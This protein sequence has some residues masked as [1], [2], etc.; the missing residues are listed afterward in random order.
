MAKT[1]HCVK[2]H[3]SVV[4]IAVF[5][6]NLARAENW[7]AWRGPAGDG[8]SS[9]TGFPLEW[10]PD[11]NVRWRVALPEP[12]NSTPIVWGDR[13]FV[14]QQMN[15][16]QQRTLICFDRRTGKQLWQ[17]G[18]DAPH[19]ERTYETNPYCAPSPVTDGETVVAWFGSA[20]LVAYD[21][22]GEELWRRPLGPVDHMF[23]YGSSPVLYGDLCLLNF[24]PGSREFAV[25]VDKK[26]GEIVWQHAAPLPSRKPEVN[27]RGEPEDMFGTW[28]TPMIV[29][30]Q[31]IFC[32][33]DEITAFEPTTGKQIWTC[34]GLGPQIL[35]T[36]IIGE[37]ML[38]ALAGIR[39]TTL[40]VRLGGSGDVTDTHTAWTIP[41]ADERL[42]TGVIHDGYLYANKINGIMQ[43]IDLESGDVVW[44]KRLAGTGRD[45]E[46]WSSLFLSD[47][48]IYAMNKSADV[49]VIEA[50]PEYKL[51][52]TNSIGGERTNSTVVGSQGNLFIRT[53]DALW[54]IGE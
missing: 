2:V 8:I 40:A 18:V 48:K 21:N 32:F 52:A 22:D 9:E 39:S 49:F 24:G 7:P 42:G 16:G 29:A 19:L 37:G 26:T 51:L 54:C 46:S 33:R 45:T 14:T 30:D 35:S 4:L 1:S 12:G 38:V 28:S 10:G 34:K 17:K 13:V 50:S 20:G 11:T 6:A 36:P 41:D 47:G 27:D 43:C 15:G 31:A 23:G 53:H 5:F 25:A 3:L 44:Q